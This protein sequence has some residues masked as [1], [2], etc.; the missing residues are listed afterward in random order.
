MEYSE[1]DKMAKTA[2]SNMSS[3]S[4]RFYSMEKLKAALKKSMPTGLFKKKRKQNGDEEVV[5]AYLFDNK[6]KER[7][8]SPKRIKEMRESFSGAP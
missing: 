5:S 8:V 2:S 7:S 6:R 1:T 4:R 3:G